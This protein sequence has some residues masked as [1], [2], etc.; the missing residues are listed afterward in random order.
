MIALLVL[1]AAPITLE[2]VRAASRQNLDALRAEIEARR[3]QLGVNVARSAILP[4]VGLTSGIQGLYAGPQVVQNFVPVRDNSGEVVA[5]AQPIGDLPF[6][7]SRNTYSLNLTVTQLIVDGGRWWNQLALSGHQARAAEGQLEEQRL[8]AELEAVNRFY[9]LLNAQFSLSVLENA[10]K[11]SET[12]LDRADSLFEAARAAK[13]DA[14]TAAVNLGNDRIAVLRQ[15]QA[16]IN[17]QVELLKWL[18]QPT[19]EIEAID[20]GSLTPDVPQRPAPK[21]EA[22]LTVARRHRP[23]LKVLDEQVAAAERQVDVAWAQ[24]FPTLNLQAG[25]QRQAPVGVTFFTD[26]NRNHAVWGGLNLSWQLFNGFGHHAQVQQARESLS[27]TRLQRERA[28]IDLTG[29]LRRAIEQLETQLQIAQIATDNLRLTEA[30]LKLAE[31]RFS[32]GAGST[33]EVRDAQVKLVN[34]QLSRLQARVDVEVARAALKRVVGADV[35]E[36][37]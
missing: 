23:L 26:P 34:A 28:E 22:A 25:Y 37:R 20:P 19:R 2:E 11:G 8:V 3:Q 30:S 13:L 24:F 9:Q 17:A 4:Q 10:V 7:T 35:E 1:L 15:R 27:Q 33:L 21:V 16:V 29:D 31:E 36:V 5:F 32:A 14:L 12:Q 18:G 6:A